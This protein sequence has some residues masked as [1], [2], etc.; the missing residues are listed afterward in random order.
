MSNYFKL[1]CAVMETFYSGIVSE[2]YTVGQATDR[3]LVEFGA[4]VRENGR[5]ALVVLSSLL[6]RTA[7]HDHS[8]LKRFAEELG[9]LALLE[10]K[11]ACQKGLNS[12]EKA[13]M[14]EDVRFIRKVL[15]G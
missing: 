4:E 15:R 5:D 13:R 3:C 1:R 12:G 10:K 9:T 8:A 11:P 2:K 7:R 6:A 14:L